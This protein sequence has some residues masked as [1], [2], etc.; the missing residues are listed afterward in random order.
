[1]KNGIKVLLI[2]LCVIQIVWSVEIWHLENPIPDGRLII[3][4]HQETY[5][6][7]DNNMNEYLVVTHTE[8]HIEPSKEP[9]N[10]SNFGLYFRFGNPNTQYKIDYVLVDNAVII[11]K[12]N[13]R[14]GSKSKNLTGI[15]ANGNEIAYLPISSNCKNNGCS[16]EIKTQYK[17]KNIIR[18]N[19]N[20]FWELNNNYF[21]V[22]PLTNN[23]RYL[24]E[25]NLPSGYESDMYYPH[26]SYLNENRI[27]LTPGGPIDWSPGLSVRFENKSYNQLVVP[28]LWAFIGAILGAIISGIFGF[29]L[30]RVYEWY[31]NKSKSQILNKNETTNQ[32]A[33]KLKN[34]KRGVK[35]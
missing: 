34:R 15:W 18:T 33:K 8:A 30:R 17:I 1:M 3:F 12:I 32:N 5:T 27:F 23:S 7:L 29:I 6:P 35:K 22:Q 21:M 19:S 16:I 20:S 31:K 14:E 10:F 25:I 9:F 24:V 28:F 13:T 26:S 4:S 2:F 11:D